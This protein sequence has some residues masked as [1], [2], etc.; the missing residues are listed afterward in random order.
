MLKVTHLLL[1]M[2]FALSSPAYAKDKGSEKGEKVR[3][4]A[5]EGDHPGQGKGRPDDPGEH[6][7]DN[8]AEKQSRG[9]GKG[10]KKDDSLEAGISEEIEGDEK[11]GNKN[12][13]KD[14]NRNK[15]KNKK[16]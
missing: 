4:V 5:S 16:K 13:N 11:A 10:S 8:A 2:V 6:G 14:K 12:K 7:R 15:E 9:H 1:L 3:E